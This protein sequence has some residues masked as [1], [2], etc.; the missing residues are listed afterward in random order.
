[1][2]QMQGR[3]VQKAIG[4]IGEE[5]VLSGDVLTDEQARHFSELAAISDPE[6]KAAKT[7]ETISRLLQEVEESNRRREAL[8]EQVGVK[9][10]QVEKF[11]QGERLSGES[12]REIDQ[13]T[14]DFQQQVMQA[15]NDE[16]TRLAGASAP[17]KAK[18]PRMGRLRV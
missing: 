2:A 17:S 4:M 11:L 13:S 9:P 7:S 8:Y 15:I 1:M 14:R 12:R 16:A 18:L 10:E 5:D 6:E 3:D